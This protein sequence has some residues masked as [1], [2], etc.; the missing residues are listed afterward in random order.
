[1]SYALRQGKPANDVAILLP[2]DDAWAGTT[3]DNLSVN[4]Q[5]NALLG[6]RLI[7]QILDAGF[8]CDLIDAT[9][10][11]KV[12]IPYKFL[13][14]PGIH[15]IPLST[16][17]A[18]RNYIRQG[19]IVIA[20]RTLPS[21]APGW[22]EA[23]MQ[24][25]QIQQ[26]SQEIFASSHARGEYLADESHLGDLLAHAMQPD[27][28]VTPQTHD[29][30]FV[31]R[32]LADG[33]LYFLV[34]TSNRP[35]AFTAAFRVAA[36]SSEWWNPDTGAASFAG[37]GN[38]IRLSLAPYESRI[39][40]LSRTVPQPSA[41]ARRALSPAEELDLSAH[42][43]VHFIQK[44]RT[45]D[46]SAL[47]SWTADKSTLYY[48]GQAEYEKTVELPS[49]FLDRVASVE[50]DFG[51]GVPFD[52]HG[53]DPSE[54]IALLDSPIREAAE[55]F[56][57]GKDAGSLWHPPY[58]LDVARYLHPGTNQLRILVGNL[59]INE[60]AGRAE[61]DYRLL[62]QFYGERF[63]PQD[64][65]NLRPIPSGLLGKLRLKVYR[66]GN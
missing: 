17:R 48:S 5:M 54:M 35:R 50:L 11:A 27:V 64:M 43:N 36:E 47:H 4:A 49:S 66:A 14:L 45:V 34:N 21:Q 9:A 41:E 13:I 62:N 53:K 37:N 26:L 65:A 24:T 52:R 22:L 38:S 7:P 20:T 3:Q 16:F 42:W 2:I 6:P 60:L 59:A 29:I 23:T 51:V 18:I 10:I 40:V 39:L 8:D 28:K 61:P 12:G 44:N 19:G 33:D 56:V 31:H 25:A 63:K 15:R 58:A 55:V 46:Y 32:R 30:G 1:V 57:N